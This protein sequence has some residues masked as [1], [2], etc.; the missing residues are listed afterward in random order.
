MAVTSESPDY[1]RD[2]A[3]QMRTLAERMNDGISKQMMLLI[4][5]DYETLGSV[6]GFDQDEST[7]E[8]DERPIVPRRLLTA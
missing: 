5:N 2:L 8:R 4:A 6:D 7:S 1:W 3:Q